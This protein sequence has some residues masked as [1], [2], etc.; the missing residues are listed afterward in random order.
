MDKEIIKIEDAKKSEAQESLEMPVGIK[1]PEELTAKAE[2]ETEIFKIENQNY[3]K[4]VETRANKEGLLFD[5][6]DRGSLNGLDNK[7]EEVKEEFIKETAP[8]EKEPEYG[9]V[10]YYLQMSKI[11]DKEEALSKLMAYVGVDSEEE[12]RNKLKESEM[13][14]FTPNDLWDASR[15]TGIKNPSLNTLRKIRDGGVAFGYSYMNTP[16]YESNVSDVIS[17]L[18]SEGKTEEAL[19]AEKI[20]AEEKRN[21]EI[22]REESEFRE[23]NPELLQMNMDKD[24]QQKYIEQQKK[25]PPDAIIYLYH[26]LNGSYKTVQ[27]VLDSPARGLEQRSGPCLS[28]I[29]VGQF[30]KKGDLGFRYALRRDQ[31]EF[32]GEKNPNAVVRMEGDGSTGTICNESGNLPFDQFEAEVMRSIGTYPD[33]NAEK[34]IKETLLHF[35]EEK[36]RKNNNT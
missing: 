32:P 20:F 13:H 9:S 1:T 7:V 23:I 6:E 3:I 31:I 28:F 16:G 26:G 27:A 15:V 24:A 12:L 29:P 21:S 30:W 17:R 36:S 34:K 10:E 18:R 8:L 22:E 25:L 5:D 33:F 4:Q 14:M 2:E 35:S 19:K 11:T